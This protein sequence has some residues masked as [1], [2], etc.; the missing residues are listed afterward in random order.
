MGAFDDQECAIAPFRFHSIDLGDIIAI[1]EFVCG[2]MRS[3]DSMER[4]AINA[5]CYI[6]SYDSSWIGEGCK[7]RRPDVR[8]VRRFASAL[9][10]GKYKTARIATEWAQS[11][12]IGISVRPR[13]IP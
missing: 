5:R 11:L 10:V 7:K 9:R 1:Q 13:C 4:N 6:L 3:A 12:P 8:K 2:S